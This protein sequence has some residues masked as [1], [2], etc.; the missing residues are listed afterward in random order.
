MS[1]MYSPRCQKHTQKKKIQIFHIHFF[2]ELMWSAHCID[3]NKKNRFIKKEEPEE[4]LSNLG[5]KF[6]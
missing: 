3:C 4:L 5:F 6:V 1:K 2:G